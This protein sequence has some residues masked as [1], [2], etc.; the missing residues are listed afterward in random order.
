MRIAIAGATGTL[1]SKVTDAARAAGHEVTVIARSAG[2]D[3]LAGVG[4]DTVLD[5]AD[6][7]VD[8]VSV[9]TVN[10][11]RAVE[12]FRT[13]TGNLVSAATRMG[14]GHVLLVSIVGVDR[15]PHGYYAGKLAQEAAVTA[16]DVPWTILRA[17]Q[18]HE[19]AAQIAAQTRMPGV[20]LAP[21]ARVQ[22]I[23]ADVLA[24]HLV[25]LVEADA[26]GR[27]QDVAGPREER[28][29]EMI[30]AWARHAGRR[31]L[32]L[33]VSLPGAQMRGMRA[34]TALPSPDALRL[35]PAFAE[36]LAAH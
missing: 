4:L 14:V 30:R 20:Q 9:S 11:R 12:F 32:V 22:P 8:L 16:S 27:A 24:A 1:G 35:G 31:G 23:S 2:I 10:E 29:D 17:T 15:N 33:P 26:T 21:R 19:F 18:F 6:A 7:L 5:G 28:L 25:G 13:A 3:L 34:G 36:W